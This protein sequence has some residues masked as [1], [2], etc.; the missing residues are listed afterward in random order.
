MCEPSL[1]GY[2]RG[3]AEAERLPNRR[4]REER[5]WVYFPPKYDVDWAMDGVRQMGASVLVGLSS[6]IFE[7]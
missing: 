1:L 5:E 7:T 2:C 3:S 4:D 6:I